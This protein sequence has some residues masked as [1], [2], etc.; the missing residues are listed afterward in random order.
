MLESDFQAKYVAVL[1]TENEA[2]QSRLVQSCSMK[3]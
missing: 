3:E 1:W 2:I